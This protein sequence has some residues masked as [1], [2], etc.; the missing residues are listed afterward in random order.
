MIV[1]VLWHWIGSRGK[2]DTS[3]IL[4]FL[5][6]IILGMSNITAFHVVVV[7]MN[8]T[9]PWSDMGAIVVGNDIGVVVDVFL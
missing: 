7:H 5:G 6:K 8:M 3:I 1:I 9:C 4:L 2:N